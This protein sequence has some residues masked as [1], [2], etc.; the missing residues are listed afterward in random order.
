M[1][2]LTRRDFLK[3]GS[4]AAGGLA[5]P[6]WGGD[7]PFE[8]LSELPQGRIAVDEIRVYKEPSYAS[9]V[10]G[11]RKRDHLVELYEQFI[12]EEGPDFNPRWYS[13]KGGYA[14]TAYI[15]PVAAIINDPVPA[16]NPNGQL[17]EVTV[18]YT[19]SQMYDRYQG[20]QPLYRLYYQSQHWVTGMEL[21]PNGRL[22]YVITDEL[23]K[24]EYLVPTEHMRPVPKEAFDP[25]SPDIEPHLKRVV[26]RIRD[27]N[28]SCY[29]NDKEVFQTSVS[30]GIPGLPSPNGIPTATPYGTF[31]IQV[32]MPVRHMGNGQITNEIGAY[33]LPGVPWSSFF[34]QTGVA[35]HG[36]YWHDNYGN[37]MSHGCVN[38]R[39]EDANWLFRWSTPVTEVGVWDKRG[40]GTKVEVV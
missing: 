2:Q 7:F 40:M 16:F 37:E 12:S 18:P 1:S 36:T 21:G 24:I 20:W 8:L 5:L 39:P 34:T 15:Q 22:G 10:V 27:Q 3:L 6:S 26:V 17:F 30:T 35:F 33:E 19:Q 38:M 32:K 31:N 4:M 11:T 25:I 14:H 9:E 28:M 29:E 13:I 23:L